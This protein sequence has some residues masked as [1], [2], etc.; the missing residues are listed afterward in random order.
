MVI[1]SLCWTCAAWTDA[2]HLDDQSGP[3]FHP[4]R[5]G[6]RA[7]LLLLPPKIG[8]AWA[9]L[10]HIAPL[11]ADARPGWQTL[12]PDGPNGNPQISWWSVAAAGCVG[13]RCHG[14]GASPC[15]P[16]RPGASA[17]PGTP[18]RGGSRC[19]TGGGRTRPRSDYLRFCC[20][21]IRPVAASASCKAPLLAEQ[22]PKR[23]TVYQPPYR[24]D[25]AA[26][27]P[28]ACSPT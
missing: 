2:P 12:W 16:Q 7:F 25:A 27:P 13:R 17:G 10:V 19:G 5:S 11:E 26:P 9:R 22:R 4:M 24:L 28:D 3:V 23:S 20:S 8:P 18:G 14:Y 6:N 21:D 1:P 15:G